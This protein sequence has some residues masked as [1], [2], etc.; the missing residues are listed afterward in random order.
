MKTEHHSVQRE[1]EQSLG[2][3]TD[4][5]SLDGGKA[6]I[7]VGWERLLGA[8]V[9]VL[10][11]ADFAA[12]GSA[13]LG[14]GMSDHEASEAIE[15][16]GG[17]LFGEAGVEQDRGDRFDEFERG[18]GDRRACSEQRDSFSVGEE[19]CARRSSDGPEVVV[20]TARTRWQLNLREDAFDQAVKQG[21]LVS[22]V[23]I[24][25][26]RVDPELGTQPAHRQPLEPLFVDDPQ[27]DGE[28]PLARDNGRAA[29]ASAGRRARMRGG[30]VDR[31]RKLFYAVDE[32][33][34]VDNLSKDGVDVVAHTGGL[35]EA[36]L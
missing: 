28:D 27:G 23:V 1:F 3:A 14:E 26:H 33:Y 19:R 9:L 25:R 12:G 2:V 35:G 8:G 11:A 21:S 15:S 24:D 16:V 34:A 13:G 29:L 7:S 17:L 4:A 6:G 10:A 30:W 5:G 31:H 22:D 36:L 20:P 32:F 18:L